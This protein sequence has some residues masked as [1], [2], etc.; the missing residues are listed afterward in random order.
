[1]KYG[2]AYGIIDL[3]KYPFENG[4]TLNKILSIIDSTEL[5]LK[6]AEVGGSF[7]DANIFNPKV[8]KESTRKSKI[9]WIENQALNSILIDLALRDAF[10][11][12][13]C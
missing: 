1:M 6:D 2:A 13:P 9:A 5:N 8:V 4:R 12:N 11:P 7:E 10:G 3:K